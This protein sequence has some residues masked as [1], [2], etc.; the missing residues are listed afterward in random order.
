MPWRTAERKVIGT[1]VIS[2]EGAPPRPPTPPTPAVQS[3]IDE[4]R[5]LKAIID[6]HGEKGSCIT[7]TTLE[8]EGKVTSEALDRH[9][10][11]FENHDALGS[12]TEEGFCGKEALKKLKNKLKMEL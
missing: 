8:S 2:E 9:I 4:H 1:V 10:R 3:F 12:I 6:R 5:K 7:R 11:L